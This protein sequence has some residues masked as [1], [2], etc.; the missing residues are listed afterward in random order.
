MTASNSGREEGNVDL[1]APK[2]RTYAAL[3]G[4]AALLFNPH[5]PIAQTSSDIN[6]SRTLLER[7]SRDKSEA[8]IAHGKIRVSVLVHGNNKY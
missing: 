4:T 3:I 1:Q 2:L 5:H 8:N 7:M 6:R